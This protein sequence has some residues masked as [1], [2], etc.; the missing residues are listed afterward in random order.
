M[1]IKRI[2]TSL[3]GIPAVVLTLAF[4]NK[5]IIGIGIL[6]ISILC[7]YEYFSVIKKIASPIEWVGY[8]SSILVILPVIFKEE[9]IF[10]IIVISIP[11]IILL[12]FLHVIVTDAK[13]TF[14]DVSYTFIGI[15]YIPFFLMFMEFIRCMDNGKILLGYAI[16]LSWGTDIFAYL[17]GK[18]FGK[19]KFT[20]ISPN[21]TVEGVIAGTIGA[22]VS[23][24]IYIYIIKRFFS[25]DYSYL[26]FLGMGIVFSIICQIG[27]LIASTIKR[28]ANAK[29]YGNILPGH[30]GMLDR[31]DSL[32]FLAPFIYLIFSF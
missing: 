6:I 18:H 27:D 19:I 23:T 10:K 12:L 22:T 15:I 29:D 4:A 32:L 26:Y 1:N 5:Y 20:K 31:I 11:I 13:Y 17:I 14:K 2:L 28:L 30:G 9:L 25:I 21:K 24:L 8:I 7:M 16:A 3:I